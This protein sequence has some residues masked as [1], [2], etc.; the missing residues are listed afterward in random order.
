M[1]VQVIERDGKPEWAI[2]PYEQYL[3]LLEQAEMLE[4]VREYDRV[5]AAVEKG[6]EEALPAEVAYA[7]IDGENPLKVWR[8]YRRMTQAQVAKVAGV[9][10]PYLSQIEAGKREPSL[11]V[12][13]AAAHALGV[14]L[15]DLVP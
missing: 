14:T 8:E 15:D 13:A 11:R 4:D 3:N 6:E 5:K 1:T 2:L 9:S 10:V 7:L 12:L